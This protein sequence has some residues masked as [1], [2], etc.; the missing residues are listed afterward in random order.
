MPGRTKGKPPN[1]GFPAAQVSMLD[2][3]AAAELELLEEVAGR[4]GDV[5]SA[6]CA[7][8]AVLDPLD[9]AGGLGAL[10]TI[11]ALAGVHCF[12]TVA[13][14]GYFGHDETPLMR[15]FGVS[16]VGGPSDWLCGVKLDRIC[17][18]FS[19]GSAHGRRETE[20]KNCV[21]AQCLSLPD[22]RAKFGTC[23]E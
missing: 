6:G 18:N 12:F 3:C 13:C 23:R 4:A 8:L 17:R 22:W 21:N 11:G 1:G 14:F 2:T 19:I 5:D 9:D 20:E 7:A 16:R 10:G 15:K